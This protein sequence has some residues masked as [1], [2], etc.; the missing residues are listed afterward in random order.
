LI[1]TEHTDAEQSM[2]GHTAVSITAQFHLQFN[3]IRV[4]F[5]WSLDQSI[6]QSIFN[7]RAHLNVTEVYKSAEQW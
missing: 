2:E 5:S 1:L 7:Y 3:F 4:T 6:N